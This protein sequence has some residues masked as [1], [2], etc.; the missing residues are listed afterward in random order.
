MTMHPL[1][2]ASVLALLLM[3][4][5][6]L[7]A[8]ARG[9]R[10]YRFDGAVGDLSNSLGNVIGQGLFGLTT[11]TAYGTL[12]QALGIA[13]FSGRSPLHWLAVFLLVDLCFYVRHRACHRV[14]ILWAV[15]EVHHQSEEYNFG[16]AQRAPWLQSLP[17]LPF[18]MGLAVLGV[19]LEMVAACF[20]FKAAYGFF[21]HT[22]LIGRLGPLEWLLV[23]PSGH[24][25]HHARN[26]QYVD[27]N[28]GNVLIVW[29]RLFGT[30]E[31]EVEAPSYGT[32]HP[33][34]TD[35][36]W[37]SNVDPFVVLFARARTAPTWWLA[38]QTLVRPP[39]WNPT[40]GREAPVASR[41]D[42]VATARPHPWRAAVGFLVC[43]TVTLVALCV[44]TIP[45]WATLLTGGVLLASLVAVTRRS[46]APVPAPLV[47]AGG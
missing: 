17:N 2:V 28:Y 22:Q 39:S 9:R 25:V 10:V 38:L 45:V 27:K 43:L 7:V 35:D 13:P 15:H 1:V 24:R 32:A 47:L 41:P 14:A 5:E 37:S 44:P 23:T 29:D 40:T 26:P 18:A 11:F 6:A 3:A 30:Y 16:T 33:R 12:Q 20:T 42:T 8:V 34:D 4:G 46:A 31:D 21:T 36:V 19:P